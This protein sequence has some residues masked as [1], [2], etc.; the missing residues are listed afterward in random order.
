VQ[1]YRDG[2]CPD[3]EEE[4][5]V[6]EGHVGEALGEVASYQLSV[7]SDQWLGVRL[8]FALAASCAEVVEEG[9]VEGLVG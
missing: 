1:D 3:G 6:D 4:Y 9:K 7:I 2:S 8:F 5:G